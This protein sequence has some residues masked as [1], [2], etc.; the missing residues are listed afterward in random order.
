MSHW[1]RG[2]SCQQTLAI[3]LLRSGGSCV[4]IVRSRTQPTEFSLV[5]AEVEVNLRLTVSQS[6]SMSWHRAHLWDLRPDIT[7]CP[8]VAVSN[9]LCCFCGALSLKRGRICN[10][11]CNHLIVRVPQN[12]NHTLLSHLRLF[13]P[14]GPGSRIYIPQEQGGPVIPP[15]TGFPL[16]RLLRPAGRR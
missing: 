16:P 15:G 11:Q 1:P 7:S 5:E 6:V 13:Q 3:S 14:G 9:L 4:S 12:P 10:L 8:N 2:T